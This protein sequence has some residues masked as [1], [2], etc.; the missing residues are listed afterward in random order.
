VARLADCADP[1]LPVNVPPPPSMVPS[2][3]PL[4][5]TKLRS[6]AI[7]SNV[8]GC[9]SQTGITQNRT[10]GLAF[11]NWALT[12]IGLYP[13]PP[14]FGRNT[15]SFMSQARQKANNNGLPASVIPE[16]V[17]DQSTTQVDILA[18]KI[19]TVTFPQSAFFE[20]KAVTAPI[21]LATSKSQILGLLDVAITKTTP[22]AGPHPPPLVLFIT[23]GGTTVAPD[24]VAQ[25]IAWK[26]AVWQQTASYN[27]NSANANDPDLRLEK[28]TCL[29]PSLYG[30]LSSYQV[31]PGATS[32]SVLTSP[33]T[34]PMDLVVP[35]DPDPAEVD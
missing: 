24:V 1:A 23:T 31:N 32:V 14:G 25:G 30:S 34:D 20:V 19:K 12:T 29:T 11:E 28:A 33:T 27:A 22:P 35:S 8:N 2:W 7:A 9:A 13:K 3:Q 10:I 16:F 5:T 26:V 18:W 21:T 17:G 4:T 15:A 6:I